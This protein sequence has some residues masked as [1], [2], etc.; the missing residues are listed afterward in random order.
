[1]LVGTFRALCIAALVVAVGGCADDTASGYLPK[2]S[3]TTSIQR[4]AAPVSRV[5]ASVSAAVAAPEVELDIPAIVRDATRIPAQLRD[6]RRTISWAALSLSVVGLANAGLLVTLVMR[7]R[8]GADVADGNATIERASV[9]DSE[10]PA[11]AMST[12]A[13]GVDSSL[14]TPTLATLATELHVAPDRYGY[15][16]APLVVAG[17]PLVYAA[18][19]RQPGPVREEAPRG[20]RRRCGCGE[21]VAPRARARR[22]EACARA[23]R[24]RAKRPATLAS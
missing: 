18:V 4:V 12:P 5:A 2:K 1:M 16:V 15:P 21:L 14:L 17:A 23:A 7:P 24:P 19:P 9:A 11:L 22:C 20:E 6:L 10:T 8:V 3:A 13:S